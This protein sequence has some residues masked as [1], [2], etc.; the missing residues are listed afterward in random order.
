MTTRGVYKKN[1][2][3]MSSAMLGCFDEED[4]PRAEFLSMIN[5]GQGAR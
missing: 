4:R 1:V 3:M 5:N 2:K